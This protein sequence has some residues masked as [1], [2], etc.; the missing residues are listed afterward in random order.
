MAELI[1]HY[2]FNSI[3]GA[4]K[5]ISLDLNLLGFEAEAKCDSSDANELR[6]KARDKIRIFYWGTRTQ[7]K[8]CVE[9]RFGYVKRDNLLISDK[10][11]EEYKI[12]VRPLG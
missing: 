7:W 10:D 4:R 6:Y 12:E 1:L 5:L 2:H 8:G 9:G 3:K 11:I